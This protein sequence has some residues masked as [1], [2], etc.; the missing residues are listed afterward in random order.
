[1]EEL[2]YEAFWRILDVMEERVLDRNQG[3]VV[4]VQNWVEYVSQSR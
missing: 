3:L 1:M 4:S 2:G